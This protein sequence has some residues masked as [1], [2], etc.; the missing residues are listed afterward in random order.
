V[1][2]NRDKF[3][4]N[5]GCTSSLHL[6]MY[7]FVGALMGMAL[8]TGDSLNLDLGGTVW[9]ALLGER[10]TIADIDG[11]DKLCISALNHLKDMSQQQFESMMLEKFTTLL[12]NGKE[13]EL[14]PNGKSTPVTYANRLQFVE[15]S[16]QA[17]IH[18]SDLAVRAMRKGL[19]AVV[20]ANMLSLFSALDLEL[21]VCGSPDIDLVAL[22]KHTNYQG[23]KPHQPVVKNLWKCLE[24]FTREERQLFIR[25]V[26]GRSR[27]PLSDSD[28]SHN[29]VVSLLPTTND[30][31][32][33]I[34]H[35]CFFSLEL[36][37]YSSYKVMRKKVLFAITN[38]QAIDVDFNPNASSLSAWVEE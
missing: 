35:T 19:H 21:L 9:K 34:S 26:W 5:P 3:V 30:D 2:L 38:T 37:N 33:P 20:P 11:I 25:F 8:R 29:F 13:F 22:R 36:P 17:R 28:W 16:I 31:K 1:G 24:S 15:L 14:K 12:S 4:I 23:C 6:R 32:L 18:E 7:E 27:L 10:V